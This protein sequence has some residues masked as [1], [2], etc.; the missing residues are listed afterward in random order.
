MM[1]R[2]GVGLVPRLTRRAALPSPHEVVLF[3]AGHPM[4]GTVS[5]HDTL[6]IQISAPALH[7]GSHQVTIASLAAGAGLS[8]RAVFA[9]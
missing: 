2:H 9:A 4:L 6:T 8:G 5:G 1:L 7:A 3:A